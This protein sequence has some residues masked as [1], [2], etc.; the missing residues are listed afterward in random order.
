MKRSR[1]KQIA[2]VVAADA[3]SKGYDYWV[4]VG[5]EPIAFSKTI[6]GQEVQIEIQVLELT[7]T[8]VQLGVSASGFGF[9][10]PCFPKGVTVLVRK[11]DQ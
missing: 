9:F 2:Q 1:L 3:A 10:S 6:D 7:E 11:V 8:F 4:L 5:D